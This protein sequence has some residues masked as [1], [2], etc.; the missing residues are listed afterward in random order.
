MSSELKE[1]LLDAIPQ[2]LRDKIATEKDA[3]TVEELKKFLI[4]RKHPL[5]IK[6]LE[7]KV[8]EEKVVEKPVAIT[9]TEKEKVEEVI[10]IPEI[11]VSM[12]GISFILKNVKIRAE[13]IVIKRAEERK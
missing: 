1:K 5:A 12:G 13:K 8:P 7:K 4:E 10:S 3:K 6:I 9:P 2:E 11:P